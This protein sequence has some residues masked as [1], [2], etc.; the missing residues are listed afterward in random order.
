MKTA[1]EI[2]VENCKTVAELDRIEQLYCQEIFSNFTL[3]KIIR[4]QRE[5]II[6]SVKR[7]CEDANVE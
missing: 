1:F 5:K 2:K 6:S 4:N 7:G 3:E